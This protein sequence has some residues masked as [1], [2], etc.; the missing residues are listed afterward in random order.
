M[1]KLKDCYRK[2]K[3]VVNYLIFGAATTFISW[4]TY[5]LF[6]GAMGMNVMAG[7]VLSWICA[8]TFAYVTNKLWV[9]ESKGW[10]WP[11]WLKEAAAFYAGRIF[12]GAV[13]IG[14]L[15]L[16]LK[17]GLDQTLFGI[18]GSVA[19]MVITVVVIVLN[20]ILSKFWIFRQD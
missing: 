5:A 1:G 14:G 17:L 16:L 19:N 15:A 10:A 20:Y 9:F 3:E 18:E 7:K 13:E 6:V 2:Y 8:V 4:L 12:S 11:G